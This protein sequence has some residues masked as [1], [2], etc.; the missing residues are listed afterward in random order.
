MTSPTRDL[1][2]AQP[3][4]PVV[5]HRFREALVATIDDAIDEE[6]AGALGQWFAEHRGSLRRVGD[7]QG[8]FR[9]HFE[10]NELDA[11]APAQLLAPLRAR[12]MKV[13]AALL[14]KLCVPEFDVRGVEMRA[15]LFH[16][17]SHY[18]WH[19]DVLDEDDEVAT[20]R[21]VAFALTLHTPTPMFSGGELEFLDGSTVA[22]RH[23]RLTLWHPVQRHR[24]RAVECYSAHVMHGR[25][26]VEG[27]LLGDA[28]DGWEERLPAIRG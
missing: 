9:F 23:N 24:V 14:D 27:W 20:D 25:W 4:P 5:P 10:T 1:Y 19:D 7:E 2:A 18:E 28:P 13:D 16:H 17:G 8:T 3:K 26:A 22:P 6:A 21:R 15:S 11:D 12:L